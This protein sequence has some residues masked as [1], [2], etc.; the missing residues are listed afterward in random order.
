MSDD[1]ATVD[2]GDAA[3]S[4][5]HGE[6][7]ERVK[8]LRIKV[9]EGYWDLSQALHEVYDNS[10]YVAW[11]YDSWKEYVEQEL[12]FALRKAQ[13]LVNIANWFGSL[14]KGVQ[15]W[16]AAM[17]WTKA[18]EL[19]G[20]VTAENAAEWKKKVQGKTV[21]QIQEL[22]KGSTSSSS[23]EGG[24]GEGGTGDGEKAS[25][26]AFQLFPAQKEN[27]EAALAL[28]QESSKS[29]KDG[30]N[31]DLIC[32][33]FMANNAGMDAD[34]YLAK[35]EKL[36]GVKIV[37]YQEST[38]SVVFGSKLLDE[39]VEVDGDEAGSADAAATG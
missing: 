14:P 29:D 22:L 15:K 24:T 39:L 23:G 11:G 7:R 1:L 27:V 5:E 13:Y 19:V 6:L 8:G 21:A 31:L 25:R 26:L 10:A 37:A 36:L 30:H 38:E 20:K 3:K 16:V 18:K 12:D 33:E 2:G 28:A 32:T 35:V 17:G 4:S 34:K 9:E